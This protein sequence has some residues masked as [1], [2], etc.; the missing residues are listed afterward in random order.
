VP[1]VARFTVALAAGL[2]VGRVL[3][4]PWPLLAAAGVLVAGLYRVHPWRGL[5]GA[6]VLVGA[7]QG[8]TLAGRE[9]ASCAQRWKAG[10][11]AAIVRLADAPGTRG[12]ADASVRFAPE[13]CRG[14]LLLRMAPMGVRSG[15]TLVVVGNHTPGGAFRVQ[16]ARALGFAQ[17]RRFVIRDAVA[18]RI[19]ALYGP[20]APVV[21]ALVLGRRG[22]IDPALRA[23]FVASGLAHLLAISGLHVGIVAA[24]LALLARAAGQHSRAAWI[25]SVGTWVY[26]ALLGFPAPAT[27]AAGFIAIRALSRS[28]QRHPHAGAVLAVAVLVVLAVDPSAV[29]AVGAWLSVAA[30]WGTFQAATVLRRHAP[31]SPAT[32]RL[33]VVS[34]GAVLATAPVSAFAF[35]QVAPVGVITNLVGVPLAG[36]IVPAVFGSLVAGSALATGGGLLLLALERLAAVGAAFPLG[37]VVGDPGIAF[38]APWCVLLGAAVWL[39]RRRPTWTV[40]RVRVSAGLAAVIWVATLRA[41]WIH[42]SYRGLSLYVLS[43]GQGDAIAIRSPHGR[44]ALMDGGPHMGPEDAGRDVVAPFLRRRGVRSLD[45]LILSHGDADHSGGVPSVVERVPPELVLEPGQPLGT[46]PYAAFL[47]AVDR[48]GA[49]WRAARRGD[50]LTWDGV[51]VEILHP[52]ADWMRHELRPNENSVVVR[53]TYGAFDA[54]LTGDAGMPVESLLVG[55]VTQVEV[56]KVGHHGSAGASGGDWLDAVAPR[57]AVISVGRGN[58]YGHPAPETLARLERR[59]VDVY[60]TDRSGT[61]TVRSDGQYFEVLRD[62]PHTLRTRWTCLVRGWLPSRASSSS[63]SACSPKPQASSRTSYTTWPSRPR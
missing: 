26:V 12:L 49:A 13:G 24:W 56:L 23:D 48:S 4:A 40:L 36:L 6:V 20:R 21:E 41:W 61:V 50:L 10:R 30:V 15:E 9:R 32:M 14:T 60:R 5:L 47:G 7:V 33:A 22:S 46:P 35:G 51:R 29:G 8:G 52:R 55:T 28:R 37:R 39:A 3:F 54:L 62:S 31:R 11:H 25:G 57:V 44:W 43:V 34:L 16:R 42:D 58:R 19:A 17:P 1:P 63:K 59:G 27:R 18:R 38:A 2:W 45:F 53:V